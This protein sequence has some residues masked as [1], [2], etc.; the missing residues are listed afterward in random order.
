MSI[1]LHFTPE[2]LSQTCFSAFHHFKDFPEHQ[3]WRR[4][5]TPSQFTVHKSTTD[6]RSADQTRTQR[7]LPAK[8]FEQRFIVLLDLR[9]GAEKESKCVNQ[10]ACIRDPKNCIRLLLVAIHTARATTCFH[11]PKSQAETLFIYIWDVGREKMKSV[12]QAAILNYSLNPKLPCY[13]A[14]KV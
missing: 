1:T 6:T 3:Q 8:H 2:F 14:V 10:I 7:S 11:D 5:L 4:S 12:I 9:K 13:E